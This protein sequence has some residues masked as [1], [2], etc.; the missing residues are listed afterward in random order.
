MGK[1]SS[2]GGAQ[3]VRAL[4]GEKFKAGWLY[5]KIW[6]EPPACSKGSGMKG[7]HALGRCVETLLWNKDQVE[8][9]EAL[10]GSGALRNCTNDGLSE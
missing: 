3:D 2:W 4:N 1:A 7:R 9:S 8:W 10:S 5:K 6:K